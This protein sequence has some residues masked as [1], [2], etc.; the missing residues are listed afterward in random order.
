M[1]KLTFYKVYSN[2]KKTWAGT[3]KTKKEAEKQLKKLDD[4][5]AIITITVLKATPSKM[6][7]KIAQEILDEMEPKHS[8]LVREYGALWLENDQQAIQIKALK[9][10]LQA[11]AESLRLHKELVEAVEAFLKREV[12]DGEM[13]TGAIILSDILTKIKSNN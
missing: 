5:F 9:E 10:Q 7:S 11:A 12:K 4:S 3:F 8:D 6:R 1:K 2:A 13:D